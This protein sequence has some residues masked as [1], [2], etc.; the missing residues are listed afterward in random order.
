MRSKPSLKEFIENGDKEK[1][2]SS[3]RDK[4][5]LRSKTILLP[6]ETLMEIKRRV[7]DESERRGHRVTEQEILGDAISD[8][9]EGHK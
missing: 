9:F 5:N 8:Y 3:L 6:E 7:I 2:H 1:S 4:K